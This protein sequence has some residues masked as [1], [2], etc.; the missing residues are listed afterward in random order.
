MLDVA[1]VSQLV[2]IQHFGV[3][4]LPGWREGAALRPFYSVDWIVERTRQESR[5]ILGLNGSV[6]LR[7]LG[8]EPWQDPARGGHRHYD[9]VA[10]REGMYTDT[11]PWAFG[12]AQPWLGAVVSVHA[13]RALEPALQ[14]ECIKSVTMHEL[15]HVFDAI[16]HTR[17]SAV[18]ERYG[19]HCTNKCIMRQGSLTRDWI[20]L[21]QDRL[22]LGPFCRDC[23]E[24]MRTFFLRGSR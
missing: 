21:T 6:V 3:W 11:A 8:E 5:V 7:L 12:V 23:A 19:V 20:N 9:V 15:G 18:E 24:G 4:R 14:V 1:G 16:P 22:R 17:R 10:L 13:F 2:P